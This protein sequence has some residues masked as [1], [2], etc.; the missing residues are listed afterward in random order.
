M[1]KRLLFVLLILVAVAGKAQLS[2]QALVLPGGE[3]TVSMGN[4][5]ELSGAAQYSYE[6]W[7]YID[8]WVENSYVYRRQIAGQFPARNRITMQLGTVSNKRIYFHV[9][10]GENRYAQL[11]NVLTTGQWQHVA[12]VYNGQ[13]ATVAEQLKV[14]VNGI[15]QT[16]AWAGITSPFA[17]TTAL[18]D[19]PFEIGVGGFKGKLD[20]VRLFNKA[21]DASELNWKNTINKYNPLFNDLIAYWKMD[22]SK[23]LPLDTKNRYDAVSWKGALTYTTV[24]DNVNFTYDKIVSSYIRHSFYETNTISDA[25]LL[26]NND[27][28]FLAVNPYADGGVFFEYPV[29]D[30]VFTNATYLSDYQGRS[31]VA[32]FDGI[33][34]KM[35]GGKDLIMTASGSVNRFTFAAWVYVDE[36]NKGAAIFRK[37]KDN[38]YNVGL[39]LGDATNQTLVFRSSNGTDN[40]A[41]VANSGLTPGKWHHVAVVFRGGAGAGKQAE[42]YVNG[43]RKEAVFKNESNTL[44]NTIAFLR[45]DFELGVDF[46]GKIDEALVNILPLSAGEVASLMKN[47]FVLNGWNSTKATA[48][49]NFDDAA[50]PTKDYR[51]WLTVL[52][53]FRKTINGNKAIKVRLGASSGEWK[54]MCANPAARQNFING[55]NE[56][57]ANNE[58]DGVDYDFEW[59][60]N[61]TEWTNYSALVQETGAKKLAGTIFSVSLHGIYYQLTQAA[62]N[63][64][65]F[66]SLQC[67]GPRASE[68]TYE[69]Y[70]EGVNKVIN[71]GV[72]ANK[73]VGGFPFQAVASNNS[74]NPPP[75]AYRTVVNQYP[76]LNPDLDVVDLTVGAVTAS[77]TFNGQ[78]TIKRKVAYSE[79]RNLRG[80]M[81]WDLATDLPITHSLSLLRALNSVYDP[82]V[83]Q[84]ERVGL[85][86]FGV[87]RGV[88]T[89]VFDPAVKSYTINDYEGAEIA[90]AVTPR[91]GALA[92]VN[93]EM[94]IPGKPIRVPLKNGR[95]EIK[96][97]VT[98]ATT[99]PVVAMMGIDPQPLLAVTPEAT[100]TV[101]IYT[102]VVNANTTLPVRLIQFNA[103]QDK[104]SIVL[105]W[106]VENNPDGG[107]FYIEHATDGKNFVPVV[108]APIQMESN[109]KNYSFTHATPA[110]GINYYRLVEKS[111]DGKVIILVTKSLPFVKAISNSFSAYPNPVKNTATVCFGK[112]EYNSLQIIDLQGR[113]LIHKQVAQ[114]Q[115]MQQIDVADLARGIYFIRL[116]GRS[117]AVGKLLKQ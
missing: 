47:G 95:N 37:Y 8:E 63:A 67:Y 101:A 10:N 46:K 50:N 19:A 62:I 27:I 55:I 88:L 83:E 111:V 113:V 11:D 106:A 4:I 97:E 65:D 16:L 42:I 38:N 53:Q 93:S 48:Y 112:D 80:V 7:V 21:L 44:S 117:C 72:P 51:T 26:A 6:A 33:G 70:V 110:V 96:V 76:N 59:A 45:E 86:T 9:S 100:T 39:E 98:V 34:A 36:W 84:V 64:T 108:P 28:I 94:V 35:N 23:G 92:S 87:D 74:Q 78:T 15:A 20:E 71:W 22:D 68:V 60:L 40:Y 89:P 107:D 56:I 114:G 32:A 116:S 41:Q 61:N 5:T 24:A 58:L 109:V 30:G 1:Q 91:A 57:I 3:A 29:N 82:H 25:S 79:E 52:E 2:N 69:K 17:S 99:D 102:L 66:I 13:A 14:Y 12:V 18:G 81:Y 85:L 31:G 75:Q 73:L 77:M 90:I 49:W 103:V 54:A 104:E 115:S 105:K 43:V